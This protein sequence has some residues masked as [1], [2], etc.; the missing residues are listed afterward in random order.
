MMSTR[1]GFFCALAVAPLFAQPFPSEVREPGIA[2][3]HSLPIRDRA[4]N[5]DGTAQ[6]TNWSGYAVTGSSFNSVKGSW[7]VP[8]AVCTGVRA[9]Q[10][11]YSALWVGLDGYNSDS[12][13]QTGTASWCNGTQPS[14]YA[15]YEFYPQPAYL[16]PFQVS[17]GNTITASVTYSGNA[18]KV[19]ITNESTKQSYSYSPTNLRSNAARS[20]A[21]WIV[22]APC[23]TNNGGILPL[24]DFGQAFFGLDYTGQTGTNYATG[25]SASGSIGSFGS[26]SYFEI[27]KVGSSSSP[28]TSTCSVLTSD[29][30]SFS[31]SW[32]Q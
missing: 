19:T 15:W 10:P 4:D 16:V 25:S 7:T 26:N 21:E 18:F 9:S 14:Y 2:P 12:V 11:E 28:Q 23:C 27:N 20:S 6:S 24:A 13:E 32:A 1:V 5:F 3:Y 22:E 29:G 8:A 31:C 17:P 30:A